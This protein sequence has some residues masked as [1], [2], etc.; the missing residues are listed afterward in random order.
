VSLL[1]KQYL[2]Y[3]LFESENKLFFL[4]K[5]RF[6]SAKTGLGL[7]F[8]TFWLIFRHQIAQNACITCVSS[9]LFYR[10]EAVLCIDIREGL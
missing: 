5:P 3:S 9:S 10:R 1:R 6:L 8:C 4:E 2:A 7:N